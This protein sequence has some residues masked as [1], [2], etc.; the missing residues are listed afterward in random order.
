MN[1]RLIS[2]CVFFGL[3]AFVS[4]AKEAG[5][6]AVAQTQPYSDTP[7]PLKTVTAATLSDRTATYWFELTS[8][9]TFTVSLQKSGT[10][11]RFR[12]FNPEGRV[13]R[14]IDCAHAGP[15]QISELASVSG[16][17]TT[18]LS[19]CA[20]NGAQISYELMLLHVGR[21]TREDKLRIAGERLTAEAESLVSEYRADT[22]Q[23]AIRKYQDA[24]NYWRAIRDHVQIVRTNIGIAK[25]YLELGEA[26]RASNY[27][28]MAYGIALEN[29]DTVTEAE[30]LLVIGTVQ[31]TQG[32]LTNAA[33]SG[34]KALELSRSAMN[35]R[36]EAEA[37]YL[38]GS[39]DYQRKQ[40]DR[41]AD[42]LQRAYTIWDS[43]GD[44]EGMTRALIFSAAVDFDSGEVDGPIET[45]KRAL[46]LFKSLNDRQGQAQVL[47]SLGNMVRVLG[48]KQQALDFYE[49]ARSLLQDSGDFIPEWNVSFNIA[50]TS[51]D[52]GESEEALQF[53]SRAFDQS[54]TLDDR[55]GVALATRGMGQAYFA[56]GDPQKALAYLD[57][58]LTATRTLSN[59]KLEANVLKDMG[60][61]Y[62]AT[63]EKSKSLQ[64]LTQAR[65]LSQ[66]LRDRR[67]E[68]SVLIGIG[69]IY[70]S[71][72]D[73]QR[74][75][76]YHEEAL[77]LSDAAEDR[78]GRLAALYRIAEC[79]RRMG[80]IEEAL[81]RT[82]TAIESIEQFRASVTG[83]GLRT[84]Y[85]ASVEQYFDLQID[86]LMQLATLK[87]VSSAGLRAFEASEASHARG[88]LD[89][90]AETKDSI[91][92]GVD[93]ALLA[94]QLSLRK[95]LDGK[96][97]RYTQLLG[98]SPG[99][100]EA[101]NLNGEIRALSAD[102]DRLQGQIKT[103]S[104]RYANL[105]QSRPLKL[106]EIQEQVLDGETLLLEYSLG[107]DNSYLWALTSTDF[108]SHFLPKRSEI[109][110]KVRQ[111]RELMTA[112]LM[113]PGETAAAAIVRVRREEQE[114]ARA[115]AELSRM[116]LGPVADRLE[117][118]RL[119]IVGEGVLQYLPF[120]A[121]PTPQS[122]QSSSPTP[123]IVEHEIVS[124]PS[125][126]TLAI[127]RNEAPLR[128]NPDQT[129]A[130]FADPVFQ[131]TDKRVVTKPSPSP[132][133]ADTTPQRATSVA[134]VNRPLRSSNGVP[135]GPSLPRL[136]A[137]QQEAKAISAMV[138]FDRQFVAMGFDANKTAAM[139]SELSRY[140]IVHFA[141][142]T[143]LNDSYPDLSSLVLS[144][145]DK[146]GK[147]QNGYLLLRDIYNLKLS[148]ELVVLSACETALGKEVKGEGLMSMVRGFMY[149]GTPR[150][151]AS[152]WKVDDEATA[153]LM[154]EFY[155][156]LLQNKRTPAA[157][158]RQAQITQMQKKSRQS[159]FFWAAFQLQGEWRP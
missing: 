109:E 119:I 61:V 62:E 35:Q 108:S 87:S 14:S 31:L 53:F 121:L 118:R 139:S 111:V 48:R 38:L 148:A 78:F 96:L 65:E 52:L 7:L 67:L 32:D 49:E 20:A 158:L 141:T 71:D 143:L 13:I 34:V 122:I 54:R 135:T 60:L 107:D 130:I 39:T 116:L 92:E 41:A 70:E 157:A 95:T 44:S 152:L 9:Q 155:K 134:A 3:I 37:L 1:H 128:G 36:V 98:V 26:K 125:A 150:V 69:H 40:A 99:S 156:E 56:K 64:F 82:E 79:L 138:S 85:F 102:Y 146:D 25:I 73:F 94:R 131:V 18:Q 127:I 4:W 21:S 115:A 105:V 55:W 151:L 28:S 57:R 145:V 110:A 50:R 142:H 17:Y 27:A 8:D 90:I 24:L 91:T 33:E 16:K 133:R 159:P 63:N 93:P 66:S 29:R 6:S 59:K 97:E 103:K 117:G 106:K 81:A 74:A 75:V 149:S 23:A 68:A 58:A 72:G 89:S 10:G 12:V 88:L 154:T 83:E 113:K 45:Q 47:T 129:L 51:L 123:L 114:Y 5:P 2:R 15:V 137:S 84:S 11:V 136:T 46:A 101:T 124:L 43:L 153:E 30:A 77:R 80:A 120:G 104:P 22:K 100:I 86:L 144:L 76:E 147:P 132:P 112:R 126:S 140:K 19:A 42:F